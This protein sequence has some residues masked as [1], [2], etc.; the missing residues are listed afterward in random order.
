MSRIA[1][2][3]I[4]LGLVA[5]CLVLLG[6]LPRALDFVGLSDFAGLAA[7]ISVMIVLTVA[8]Q[9]EKQRSH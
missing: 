3:M 2:T 6:L 5:L 1:A 8:A 9:I 4:V 7:L